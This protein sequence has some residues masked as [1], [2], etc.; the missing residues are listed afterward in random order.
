MKNPNDVAER[1][2]AIWNEGDADKRRAL[3]E[4]AWTPD[5]TY[6][7]PM[8]QGEGHDNLNAMIGAAQE[9]FPGLRFTRVGEA[10][11][12]GNCVRFSWQLAPKTA[13]GE[14]DALAGGTDFCVLS[15]DGRL[16][17]VTGFVDF[18]NAPPANA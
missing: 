12:V 2:L 9:Q 7:D 16:Q 1:Y 4:Q 14:E 18:F 5:A 6:L 15:G 10:Q 17:S 13:T 11:N 3:I 8:M